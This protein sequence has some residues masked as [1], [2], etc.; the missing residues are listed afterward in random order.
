[1]DREV[2]WD[3]LAGWTEA[4]RPTWDSR[5][6]MREFLEDVTR[7]VCERGTAYG[8]PEDNHARTAELFA[9]FDRWQHEGCKDSFDI[10]LMNI[11]QKVSRLMET[12]QVD[13]LKD[14]AGFAANGYTCLKT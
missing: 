8:P 6:H 1:M 5:A 11:L 14:L 3:E 2:R 12:R 4:N 10:C 9:W 7:I 13:G